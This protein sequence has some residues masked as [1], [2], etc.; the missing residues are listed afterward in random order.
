AKKTIIFLDIVTLLD[1]P[2]TLKNP[3]PGTLPGLP[4]TIQDAIPRRKRVGAG[5][6]RE[7]SNPTGTKGGYRPP[8]RLSAVPPIQEW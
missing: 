3:K 5:P 2:E 8:V 1:G 6:A 7:A 4:L